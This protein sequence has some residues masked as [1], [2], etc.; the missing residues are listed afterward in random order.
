MAQIT[1]NT[2]NAA[3]KKMAE[4]WHL[5]DALMG[6]TLAMR[7]QAQ[8]YLPEYPK[9]TRDRYIVRLN[10]SVLLEEFKKTVQDLLR[11]RGSN[12]CT[13]YIV[14]NLHTNNGGHTA[15]GPGLQ[16]MLS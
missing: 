3:Y 9:E 10:N 11:T 14:E 8:K 1:V 16:A 6:G 12:G 4:K 13:T 7:H 2:P 5:I 15:Q